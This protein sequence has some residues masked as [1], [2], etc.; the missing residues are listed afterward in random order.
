MQ[1]ERRFRRTVHASLV[2]AVRMEHTS[3]A[4]YVSAKS[5]QPA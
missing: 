2:L 3:E 1:T 5:L 4:K